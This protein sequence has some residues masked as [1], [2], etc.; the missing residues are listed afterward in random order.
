MW[1]DIEVDRRTST[2]VRVIGSPRFRW[3]E[4]ERIDLSSGGSPGLSYGVQRDFTADEWR[5]V[6]E[7]DGDFSVV[8]I[9]LTTDSAIAGFDR[10]ISWSWTRARE[11]QTR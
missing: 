10:L 9:E 11:R 2:V 7:A 1:T 5:R 4:I 8:G 6:V 3:L